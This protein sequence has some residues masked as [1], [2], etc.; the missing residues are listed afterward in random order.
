[1]FAEMMTAH[2]MAQYIG[3]NEVGCRVVPQRSPGYYGQAL[4]ILGGQLFAISGNLVAS[5]E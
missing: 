2:S 5:I 1:M 3:S 4:P